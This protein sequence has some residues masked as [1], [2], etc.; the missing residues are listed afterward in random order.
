MKTHQLFWKNVEKNEYCRDGHTSLCQWLDKKIANVVSNHAM[1]SPMEKVERVLKDFEELSMVSPSSMTKITTLRWVRCFGGPSLGKLSTWNALQK[2][3]LVHSFKMSNY[4]C[5]R[6]LEIDCGNNYSQ[7]TGVFEK[8]L[9]YTVC[10]VTAKQDAI[11]P[12]RSKCWNVKNKQLIIFLQQQLRKEGAKLAN[13]YV[14]EV[15]RK[16]TLTSF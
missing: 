13:K 3:V 4:L 1:V 11:G 5:D 10:P 7:P 14:P 2:M 9:A 15:Q 6:C 16:S 12:S 8:H